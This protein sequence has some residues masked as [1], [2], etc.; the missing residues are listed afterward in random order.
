[1]DWFSPAFFA[2]LASII[3]VDLVL[4]GD[5]ALVI[6][7]AAR[8]LP[9]HLQKRAILFGTL[10]AIVVRALLTLVVFWLL[11]IPFLLLM[12]GLILIWIAYNLLTEKNTE[13]EEAYHTRSLMEAIRT[14][15]VA[16]VVMGLDNVLAI[17]GVSH[18]SMLLVVL[19][20]LVSVPIMVWSSTLI[21]KLLRRY[22][23]ISYLGAGVLSWTASGMIADEPRLRPYLAPF[24]WLIWS[25][26]IAVVVGVLLTGWWQRTHSAIR[27]QG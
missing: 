25:F 23:Q 18:G 12:G 9:D 17:A 15:V 1:M 11:K 16:D 26:Q 8:S 14:I 2:S 10:A 4:A 7:M 22:P 19:G 3:I 27:E 6:G 21:V 20:L 5:N 13:K 24:P